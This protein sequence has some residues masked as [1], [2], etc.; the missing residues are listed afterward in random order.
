MNAYLEPQFHQ[1]APLRLLAQGDPATEIVD[2]ATREGVSL[3]MMPTR[4]AGLFRKLLLGSVT[5]KVLHDAPCPV[6][7]N[8]HSEHVTPASYPSRT[9]V[10]AV[11]LSKRS[12]QVLRW[13]S[14]FAFEQNAEMHVVHAL[15]VEEQS[16]NPGVLEVRRYLCANALEQWQHLEKELDI[17]KALH[18]AY[19]SAGDAVR[20]A[21]HDLQ[22]D[23]VIIGRGHINEPLGRLRTNSYSIIRESPC[24]V[25][26]V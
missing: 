25:I 14:Q 9:I 6:W 7:T 19:G 18:I 22:A 12:A 8:S 5:A 20:K 24:P 26:S 23:L 2:F 21:A 17:K 3:I 1:L 15:D 11:D 16:T 13:A 4:G 10:C